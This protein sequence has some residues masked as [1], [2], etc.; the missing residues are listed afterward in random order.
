MTSHYTRRAFLHAA[1]FALGSG[2]GAFTSTIGRPVRSGG[3]IMLSRSQPMASNSPD[4]VPNTPKPS[5]ALSLT[6]LQ[7]EAAA[8]ARE[9]LP[10]HFAQ[11]GQINVFQGYMLEPDGELLLLRARDS[12]LPIMGDLDDVSVALR[13][14]Y[15]VS[16]V[17]HG[18]IG[19][20]YRFTPRPR[21]GDSAGARVWDAQDSR[22]VTA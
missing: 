9:P 15:A 19:C 6:R 7:A 12:T 18:A 8:H 17:Y 20:K 1:V 22:Y 16:P 13:N 10:E 14:S 21:P 5:L 2:E 3:D 4:V 11:L